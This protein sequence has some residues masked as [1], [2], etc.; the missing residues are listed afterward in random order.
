MLTV[1]TDSRIQTLTQILERNPLS[2]NGMMI[3]GVPGFVVRMH[4][5]YLMAGGDQ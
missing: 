2:V 5:E 1:R 3:S 4:K